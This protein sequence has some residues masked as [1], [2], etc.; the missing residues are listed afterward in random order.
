M[1]LVEGTVEDFTLRRTML[2]DADGT[3]HHV[4]NGQIIVASNLSR[5]KQ[6]A[7]S[8][9]G[10]ALE[11]MRISIAAEADATVSPMAEGRPA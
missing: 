4:P 11:A 2:R 8:R 6:T 3:V 10:R 9:L 1:S 7:K 5:G